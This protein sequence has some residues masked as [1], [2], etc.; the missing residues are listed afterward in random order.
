MRLHVLEEGLRPLQK[1]AIRFLK[2]VLRGEVPG[3]VLVVSY[4]R[5]L[6]GKHIAACYQQALRGAKEWSIGECELFAAFV[7]RLNECRY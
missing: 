7:S 3:P 6:F 4:R 5:E 1:V 2:L